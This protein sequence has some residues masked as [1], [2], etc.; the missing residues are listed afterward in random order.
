MTRLRFASLLVF[1]A[2]AIGVYLSGAPEGLDPERFRAWLRGAGP[3]GGALFVASCCILQPLGVRSVFFTLTAPLI[4]ST[5][6]AFVLSWLGA[7]AGSLAAF[8]FARFVA[9][10]WV[11]R[12]LPVGVRRLDDRLVTHGF[13][14]VLLL[15]L[16]FYTTPVLQYALGIS[17]VRFAPF[18]LGTA[19][20]LVPLTAIMTVL[21]AGIAEWLA[22][23]PVSAWPWERFGPFI[24]AGII[25]VVG[26][27]LVA[28]RRW[29]ANLSFIRKA[30]SDL[31]LEQNP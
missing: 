5:S 24:L 13:R 31:T 19:L 17:R 2:L 25:A 29:Q 18:A 28:I 20:G 21:G 10:D 26:V 15:R 14:T 27:A 16:V 30:T 9:W 3:W 23:H 11:R 22:V 8:G 1:L 7:V 4:W 6:T 12:R